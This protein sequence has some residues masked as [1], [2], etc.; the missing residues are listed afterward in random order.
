[1]RRLRLKTDKQPRCHTPSADQSWLVQAVAPENT[2]AVLPSR[3]KST[4]LIQR[5]APPTG[6]QLT[7]KA[8]RRTQRMSKA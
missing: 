3:P 1:M 5:D 8:Q 4:R 2:R 7:P 6:Q